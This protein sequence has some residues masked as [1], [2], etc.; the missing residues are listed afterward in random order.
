[1]A[2]VFR[3]TYK[4]ALPAGSEVVTRRGERLARW[5]DRR[6]R[7]RTAPLSEDGTQIVLTYRC[8]YIAYENRD[9]RRVVEQGFTDREATEQKARELE[10]NAGRARAGLEVVDPEKAF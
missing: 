7:V 2:S 6:G 3:Q 5:K 9:G 10:R 4:R 1:M 8:W